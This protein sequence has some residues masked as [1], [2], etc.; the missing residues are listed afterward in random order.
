MSRS[1]SLYSFTFSSV[2]FLYV[3]GY[4]ISALHIHA[5]EKLKVYLIL[6]N[7]KNCT[8]FNV[9]YAVCQN[10]TVYIEKPRYFYC[11]DMSAGLK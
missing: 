7:C 9:I 11:S 10:T 5:L 6:A 1:V 8:V 4:K 3:I 2:E